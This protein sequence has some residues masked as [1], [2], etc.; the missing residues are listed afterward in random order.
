MF[1]SESYSEWGGIKISTVKQ[2]SLVQSLSLKAKLFK[3]FSDPSRL[4]ILES[5]RDKELSV[6]DIVKSTNLSQANVSSHLNCLLQ[7]GLVVKREEGK[8]NYY[9]IKNERVLRILTDAEELLRISTKEAYQ[10]F[11][12]CFVERKS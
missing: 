8:Y 10:C 6:G 1:I 12:T 7:A 5:L 3:G 9:S 2:L 11:N 4:A